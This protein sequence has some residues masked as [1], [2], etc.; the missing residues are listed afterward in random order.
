[1]GFRLVITRVRALLARLLRL[2][3]ESKT[4]LNCDARVSDRLSRFAEERQNNEG[5]ERRQTLN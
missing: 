1:M 2:A 5:C 3:R 4:L